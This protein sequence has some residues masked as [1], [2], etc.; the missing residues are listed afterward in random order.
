MKLNEKTLELIEEQHFRYMIVVRLMNTA[1]AI[2]LKPSRYDE[3]LKPISDLINNFK[4]ARDTVYE[5]EELMNI[6]MK[7]FERIILPYIN[8]QLL[9]LISD[10]SE[11]LSSATRPVKEKIGLESLFL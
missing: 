11:E 9:Y 10:L 4:L 1:N 8:S 5:D 7:A 3:K 2:G 6:T